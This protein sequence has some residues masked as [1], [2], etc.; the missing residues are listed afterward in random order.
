MQINYSNILKSELK[1]HV[2]H[3]IKGEKKFENIVIDSSP[4]LKTPTFFAENYDFFLDLLGF[5]K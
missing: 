3:K 2:M 5:A 1:T 4:V